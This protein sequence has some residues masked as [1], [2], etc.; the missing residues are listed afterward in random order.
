MSDTDAHI[1]LTNDRLQSLDILRGIALCGILVM[2]IVSFALP[3][4][5]YS[6]PT[7]TDNTLLSNHLMFAFTHIFFDQKMMGLFSL[8]F[9][10]SAMLFIE[11]LRQ[12]GLPSWAFYYSRI[13]WLMVFGILHGIFLWQGDILFYYAMCGLLLFFF[14]YLPKL[15]TLIIG[16]CVFAGA[17]FVGEAGQQWI[18]EM[19]TYQSD[20]YNWAWTSSKRD[21]DLEIE[22]RTSTYSDLVRYRIDTSELNLHYS[23]SIIS[24]IFIGQGILRALGLMIIGMALYRLG[25]FTWR[26]PKY[27]ALTALTIGIGLACFGL[28]QQYQHEWAI[29]YSMFRGRTYNHIATPF[30]TFAYLLIVL[31]IIQ[32][33]LA[34]VKVAFVSKTVANYGRLAFSNYISQSLICTS[35]FYGYGFSLFASLHRW[36]LALI[37]L[38][39]IAGQLILSN[40]WLKYF[41][42]GPLEW[43]WRCLTFFKLPRS[44]S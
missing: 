11:K 17:I 19:P 15:L 4:T 28:W 22:L 6:N 16:L 1:V 10:A 40:I 8:L 32:K 5:A 13:F 27:L 35:L 26:P 43:L 18:S 3:A 36:Q 37:V 25:A 23:L 12:K 2:N 39:I 7:V 41:N 9:G 30:L 20:Y 31:S 44:A 34:S 38:A 21:I 33:P 29:Q 14:Q 24:R 42:Y